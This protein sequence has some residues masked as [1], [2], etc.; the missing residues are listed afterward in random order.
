M[1]RTDNAENASSDMDWVESHEPVSV[2]V[3]DDSHGRPRPAPERQSRAKRR[4]RN[5]TLIHA[6]PREAITKVF[7]FLHSRG[8]K[9][10]EC[11][12]ISDL[13]PL[14]P[15]RLVSVSFRDAFDGHV[16]SLDLSS[17]QMNLL[18]KALTSILP[19]FR[20]LSTLSLSDSAL[21]EEMRPSW[22][23]FFQEKNLRLRHLILS[24]KRDVVGDAMFPPDLATAS[25]VASS[26]SLS[27]ETLS[28]DCNVLTLAV[29]RHCKNIQTANLL[30]DSIMEEGLIGFRSVRSL[31]LVYRKGITADKASRLTE[32]LEKIKHGRM[33]VHVRANQLRSSQFEM[34]PHV[35][36]LWKVSIFDGFIED[37]VRGMKMLA[38]CFQLREIQFEWVR[39][40]TGQDVA[41][42]AR[43]M[44]ER[45]MRIRI[46]E[47]GE[48]SDEAL[49][50]L[51]EWCP[52]VEV[53]LRFLR[54]QFSQGALSLL[55]DR[56]SWG[57]YAF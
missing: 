30:M 32:S 5:P 22:M 41:V 3:N 42:L 18:Q 19:K 45:L 54:D 38:N 26:C 16:S 56:V 24:S 4:R 8:S 15:L 6:L 34:F 1:D 50:A 27:L 12:P 51:A 36:G 52:H 55:G 2:G 17:V 9:S 10:D 28:T 48:V 11:M 20:K 57:S 49:S 43:E 29:A 23:A 40:L 7:R 13:T 25:L 46:W 37:R 47:C 44:K 39:N 21:S 31:G 35:P 33:L 14:L 53:E